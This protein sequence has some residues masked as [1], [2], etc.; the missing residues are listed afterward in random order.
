M[1][2]GD[3]WEAKV[4]VA[5]PTQVGIN[6]RHYLVDAQA[7]LGATAAQIAG[8]FGTLVQAEYKDCMSNEAT[9]RGVSMQK[10]APGP[11]EAI[12]YSTASA[13]PGAVASEM[14]PKQVSGIITWTTALAGRSNRGRTY[15]P[16]PT[17]SFQT[18]D[19]KPNASYMTVLG[20]LAA[21]LASSVAAGGGGNTSTLIPCVWSRI[22]GI[23]NPITNW[24][25]RQ[26]WATQ[27]RRGDYGALNLPPI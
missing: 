9:F 16:F 15:V 3:L 24:T 11:V 2:I 10:L 14:L 20:N 21:V 25:P 19:G 23:V 4:Y 1:A 22:L 26:K 17:E 27:R 5:T 6:V 18:L 7:G 8:A 13:G 12:Q